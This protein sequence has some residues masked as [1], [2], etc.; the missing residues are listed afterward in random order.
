MRIPPPVHVIALVV[1]ALA[2]HVIAAQ[3]AGL[4]AVIGG[5]ALPPAR[6]ASIVVDAST[7]DVDAATLVLDLGRSKSPAVGD[8]V[9]VVGGSATIFKG[10]V[11]GLEPSKDGSRVTVRGFN[12]LHRLTRGRKSKTYEKQTDADIVSRIARDAGL[13]AGPALPETSEHHDYIIQNNQTDLEFLRERAARIGFEVVVDDKTLMLRPPIDSDPTPLGCSTQTTLTR[14]HPRLSSASQLSAVIVRGWDPQQK[15]EI[16]GKASRRLIK[17][18]SGAGKTEDSPG[19][20]IDLG[21]VL[22]IDSASAAYGA[23]KGTLAAMTATDLSAEAEATG[24]AS[25]RVGATVSISG[26]DPRFGG[27]YYVI[28]V[29]HR[30]QPGPQGSDGSWRTLIR[31]V[32]TDRG[33]YTLPEVGDEVLVAFEHGDVARPFIVG[34]LWNGSDSAIGHGKPPDPRDLVCLRP[35]KHTVGRH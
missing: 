18:S 14:F 11:V 1:G 32:R 6:V 27:K 9:D 23:A 29:S 28:G 31:G 25:L 22:G 13:V 17:L 20:V 16:V 4:Q 5:A 10:E 19:E 21:L 2:S 26:L 7:S 35:S 30:S 15:K 12:R 24:D 3:N 34:S 8:P 33:F